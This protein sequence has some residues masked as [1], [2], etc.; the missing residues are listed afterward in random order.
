DIGAGYGMLKE[1]VEQNTKLHYVGV[2]VYPKIEG[3]CQIGP[4]GSTLP[5]NIAG[6][7]FGIVACINVF[8]H[9]SIKQRRHYYEQI[10]KILY[11]KWGIFSSTH[12]T[13]RPN[14]ARR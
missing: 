14:A 2:D 6:S 3:I 8:E 11:P 13:Y 4:D 9:M 1:F 7:L 5:P 12:C 10:E